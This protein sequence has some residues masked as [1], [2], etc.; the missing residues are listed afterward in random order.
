MALIIQKFGGT[1]VATLDR[2]KQI[3][4]IVNK[5]LLLGNQVIVVVS[6]MAEVTDNLVTLANESSNL[7]T[8]EKIAE[9]DSILA[10]GEQVTA[11][12]LALN[13]LE[14]NIKSRSLLSWQVKIHTDDNYSN[15]CII[16]IETNLINQ[17][18]NDNYVPIIAGFQGIDNLNRLTTLGRGG[19][20]ISAVALAAKLNATRCDLY[21]DVEGIF[22]ADP[23][24]VED[25]IKL[26]QITYQEMHGLAEAGAKVLNA[27]AVEIAM[28][29]DLKIH[30]LSSFEDKKGTEIINYLYS[31]KQTHITAISQTSKKA[32][33]TA[34]DVQDQ[35]LIC[36][37]LVEAK[38]KFDILKS[39]LN[40]QTSLDLTLSF[41]KS[42]TKKVTEIFEQQN[43]LNFAIENKLAQITLVGFINDDEINLIKDMYKI[44]N[45]RGINIL[46]I[47]KSTTKIILIINEEYK[48]LVVRALHNELCVG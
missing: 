30:V 47:T 41:D 12:L 35:N 31:N 38:I 19:S 25:A 1:S 34:N 27:K 18:I 17:L 46:F 24:I 23:K 20:D 13:L 14:M 10:S 32:I 40:Y 43:Y 22:T 4:K 11:G 16:D 28:K 15:A 3:A 44:L 9:Y 21:K 36:N 45:D 6:A 33:L 42:D 7:E 2:I 8:K 37:Y 29:A 48:E 39:N 26:N 5:E